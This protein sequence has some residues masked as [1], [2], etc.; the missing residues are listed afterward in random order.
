M[1][2]QWRGSLT[3]EYKMILSSI[4]VLSWILLFVFVLAHKNKFPL[5]IVQAG[6]LVAL[7]V[8]MAL[9]SLFMLGRSH[10]LP[11]SG[12]YKVESIT[13][14][15]YDQQKTMGIRIRSVEDYEL[16]WVEFNIKEL[17]GF[18]H[19]CEKRGMD[20]GCLKIDSFFWAGDTTAEVVPC[21]DEALKPYDGC[22]Q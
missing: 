13:L 20:C 6:R 5:N 3:T 10:L 14:P 2:R 11:D 7:M 12:I 22:N 15:K 21:P 9:S 17:D 4:C 1:V 18:N 19:C 8:F 16:V